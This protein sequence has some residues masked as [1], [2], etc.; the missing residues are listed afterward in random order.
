MKLADIIETFISGDWGEESPS[1]IPLMQYIVLGVQI[2][3]PLLIIV[4]MTYRS[5]MFAKE[6]LIQRCFRLE[7]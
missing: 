5:A 2:L 4:L 6:R 7:I 3:Y 1:M